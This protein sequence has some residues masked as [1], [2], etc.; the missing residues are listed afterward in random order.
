VRTLPGVLSI[1]HVTGQTDYLLWVAAADAH[2]LREFVVE[3]LASDPAV[4]HAETSLIYEQR[5]RPRGVRGRPGIGRSEAVGGVLSCGRSTTA[6]QDGSAP[7]DDRREGILRTGA[8]RTAGPAGLWP[9]LAQEALE[10][11]RD[12]VAAGEVLRTH[13]RL[14]LLGGLLE[15]LDEGLHVGVALTA[16]ETWRS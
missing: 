7:A 13:R 9:A 4:S 15:A 12:G 6:G 16:S 8:G 3:H 5:P 10:L 14:L 1:F 2:D 11:A